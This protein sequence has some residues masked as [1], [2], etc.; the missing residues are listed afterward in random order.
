MDLLVPKERNIL[1]WLQD[2]IKGYDV[3]YFRI[4]SHESRG[5]SL[6]TPE[7]ES[8]KVVWHESETSEGQNRIRE[9]K[10]ED[11]SFF[12][13]LLLAISYAIL[14]TV[15]A[16]HQFTVFNLLQCIIIDT[17]EHIRA[18][19]PPQ[20]NLVHHRNLPRRFDTYPIGIFLE[21][22]VSGV[23][24]ESSSTLLSNP[25]I[26]SQPLRR[27]YFLLYVERKDEDDNKVTKPE[28]T[29]YKTENMLKFDIGE[30][31]RGFHGVKEER[32]RLPG[33]KTHRIY[34]AKGGKARGI[35]EEMGKAKQN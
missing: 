28:R 25:L 12:S 16:I 26:Q 14:S 32:F 27:N 33:T 9:E 31:E 11:I 5:G 20:G 19:D 21:R 29:K 22:G 35:F 1:S 3:T 24:P 30:E 6:A 15:D 17:K 10:A 34:R 8:R 18:V 13:R 23:C 7:R 2:L 4:S